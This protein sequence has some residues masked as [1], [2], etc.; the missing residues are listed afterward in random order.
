MNRKTPKTKKVFWLEE[1]KYSMKAETELRRIIATSILKSKSLRSDDVTEM[2]RSINHAISRAV[3][4]RD[5]HP[6]SGAR[7]DVCF[8]SLESAKRKFIKT[9][10]QISPD[11]LAA[12]R[13]HYLSELEDQR[14]SK[15]Y[16]DLGFRE[17]WYTEQGIADGIE[18]T[19]RIMN[20]MIE[21][22]QPRQGLPIGTRPKNEFIRSCVSEILGVYL[23]YKKID[24]QTALPALGSGRV[25]EQLI[26]AAIR[27]AITH[28]PEKLKLSV[29]EII[30]EFIKA[31]PVSTDKI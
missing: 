17:A 2:F 23:Q 21:A 3:S 19:E 20:A 14:H 26:C 8:A 11:D 12:L 10:Y 28:P 24:F 13:M 22:L 31:T 30:Q 7:F 6:T 15:E 4:A 29:R 18:H 1:F 5:T 25:F 9:L 16:L 27:P